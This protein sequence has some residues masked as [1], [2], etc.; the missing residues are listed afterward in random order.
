[1]VDE[2]S[3]GSLY[4]GWTDPAV[5]AWHVREEA[6]HAEILGELVFRE[7]D[8]IRPSPRDGAARGVPQSA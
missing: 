4:G 8:S 5:H 7:N 3:E 1:M 6:R 2:A